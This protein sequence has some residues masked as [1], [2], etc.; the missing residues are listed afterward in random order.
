MSNFLILIHRFFLSHKFLFYLFLIGF[1]FFIMVFA[2]QMVFEEDISGAV[3]DPTDSTRLNEVVSHFK[4]SEKLIVNISFSDTS[5]NAD[6]QK[7]ATYAEIFLDSLTTRFDSNYISAINGKVSDSIITFWFGY[8][9]QHLPFYLEEKDYERIKELIRKDSVRNLIR[10][11]Y[12]TLISPAGFAMKKFILQ[13]PIG[14]SFIAMNK[15]KSIQTGENYIISQGF[16][17]TK[18]LKNLLIFI[19]PANPSNETSKNARLIYGIDQFL[20]HLNLESGSQIKG[21]C[22]GSVAMAVGNAQQ[23][24][25]DILVT[26]SIAFVLIVLFTGFYFKSIKIPLLG[27]LPA[28]FGG[29]FALAV[30][31]L[32]KGH[33]SV[34]ALGIGSVILGLIIDYALYFINQFRKKGDVEAVLKELSLTIFLCCLTSAGAFICLIFLRS[35]VLNDLGLFAALSVA[36]AAFF[37]LVI[38]PQFLTQSDSN[39]WR[40]PVGFR[41]VDR[42]SVIKFENKTWLIMALFLF[43]IVSLFFFRKVDFEKDMMALNFVTPKLHQ[44]ETEVNRITDV[45]LKNIYI[46][47]SGDK[48]ETSLRLQEKV[49]NQLQSLKERNIIRTYSGIGSVILSD[50]LQQSRIRMWNEF[51]TNDRKKKLKENIFQEAKRFRFTNTAFAPFFDLL[52]KKFEPL[53]KPGLANAKSIFGKDWITETDGLTMV[54]SIAKVKQED[55]E[56]VY[57]VFKETPGVIVF[58]RQSL[59]NRFVENVKHDFELLVTLSMIFVTL[60]LLISFGRIELAL[61]TALPMYFSWLIT[62]GFMGLTGIKFNIFNIIISSFVFGLGVDYSIIMMRALQ[63]QYKYG[64]SDIDTY[65]I[66]VFLSSAT[67]LFGVGALFFARH[68]ALNSIALIAIVGVSTVVLTSYT[69]QPLLSNWFFLSRLKKQKF[70]V[71]ARIF[72]KTFITWGNITLIGIIMI[73]TGMILNLLI[74]VKR[75]KKEIWFHTLFSKLS[76]A[77]LAVTFP[78]SKRKLI[79]TQGEDFSKPSIIISNHQ[80]LIETPA[81]LRL[82]PKIIMLTN[83]WVWNSLLTG[84]LAR[85]A[86]FFNADHGI[87]AIL[88]KLK[89]KVDEGYSILVF[90]EAHRSDD[91]RI[92]RFHRGAFYM[93]EKLHLDI[94]PIV[95]FGSGDFLPRNAFWG[96]PNAFHMKILR[97]VSPEDLS[98]GSTYSERTKRFRHFYKEQYREFKAE[99]GTCNYYRRLLILNYVFKGPILEWYLRVKMKLSSNYELFHKLLP[100]NGRILD[101]GCGYGFITYML[102]L[103]GENRLITGVDY[104]PE[105]IEVAKNGFLKNDKIEFICTDITTFPI[106]RY[107]AFIFSDVLHYLAERDQENLLKRCIENLNPGGTILIRDADDNKTK[108]HRGTKLTEFFSTR[109]LGFNKTRINREL[110]FT[111]LEQL[112]RIVQEHQMSIEVIE[113]ARHTSNLL[114]II[115]H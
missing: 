38:L 108:K 113:E 25:Q 115:R 53:D 106:D 109:I 24:K 61:I 39:R 98:F 95:V 23:L 75:K 5:K 86:S 89:D 73:I 100:S 8:I 16:I 59:T 55:K 11:D 85:L 63:H 20:Q 43:G 78:P 47:S 67:T 1:I 77:Y 99:Y 107:D 111:S 72:I 13:D 90:P 28:L 45:S 81:F 94:L 91:H 68:P 3:K 32:I 88:D 80:S 30:L 101:I 69:F 92:Q 62:L 71:T 79:N 93:A 2:S 52:D 17:F 66:S 7:L 74:P 50:S 29:G 46:V 14:I 112:T 48:T 96:R 56:A 104:D 37:A 87:D 76:G 82:H 103:T 44:A 51:W 60:L 97:R 42:I 105:K 36:G 31:Y 27:F 40:R 114:I 70:P 54:Y 110:Y 64:S 26:I 34:I 6:P 83:D 102:N 84:P 49:Q 65:K 35:T 41:F 22:F 15:L 19:T 12:T 9:Y 10:K 18:D 4:F 21:S 33:V 57:S 58:D